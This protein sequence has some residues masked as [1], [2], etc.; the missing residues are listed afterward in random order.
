MFSL[1]VVIWDTFVCGVLD[2]P[3]CGLLGEARQLREGL[4]PPWPRR[5]QPTVPPDIE[6]LAECCWATEPEDR[7][8]AGA[9]SAKLLVFARAAVARTE[10]DVEALETGLAGD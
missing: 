7:P 9:V 3:L 8:T 1:G 10:V 6:R 2:N 5:P 4:R